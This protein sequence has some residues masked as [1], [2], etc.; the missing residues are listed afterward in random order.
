M[1]DD[2]PVMAS[3]TCRAA[4]QRAVG[5]VFF[6]TGFEEYQP[7][8]ID[9]MTDL[10]TDFMVRLGKTLIEYMERPKVKKGEESKNRTGSKLK[11]KH[12]LEEALLLSLNANGIDPESLEVYGKDDAEKFSVKLATMHER[13][14]G[15]LSDLLR[16]ALAADAGPDGVNAFNDGSEQ[17]L[18]GDF[19][20][21]LGE[22]F[23]GFKELGLDKEFGLAG[24]SVPLHLL[25]NRMHRNYQSQSTKLV[26]SSSGVSRLTDIVLP[27]MQ[28]QVIQL[29]RHL[30]LS[31]RRTINQRLES[32]TIFLTLSY[33]KT[34]T[35]HL[36]RM[37]IC[38]RNNVFQNRVYHQMARS[39]PHAKGLS[40]KPDQVKVIPRR[41]CGML[42]A[43]AGLKRV[44]LQSDKLVKL[45][46]LQHKSKRTRS[47]AANLSNQCPPMILTKMQ[48]EKMIL[49]CQTA[50]W[51]KRKKE[52]TL[53]ILA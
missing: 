44:N 1:S 19:A 34:I 14:K 45:R 33:R 3:Y 47:L 52:T 36:Q 4:M 8:A 16:P 10:A 25:H 28:H 13:M 29:P 2:G 48:L 31:Q 42:K 20:E 7:S 35:N 41:K 5:K 27:Q 46:N 24:L 26:S 38:H 11:A 6:N 53:E 15:H 30:N 21:D 39:R 32:C 51:I 22:D 23:F 40:K 9:A 49:R 37:K 12:T 50:S 43:R 18:G 17:F